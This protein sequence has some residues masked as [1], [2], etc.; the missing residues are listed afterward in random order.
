M[1]ISYSILILLITILFFR[2]FKKYNT[3]LNPATIFILYQIIF[4]TIISSFTAIT[5]FENENS[6]IFYIIKT[7]NLTSLYVFG[8]IITYFLSLS[9]IKK[10]NGYL[11]TNYFLRMEN[12]IIIKRNIIIFILLFIGI[13]AFILLAVIGNGG[14]LWFINSREA[15]INFRNGAGIFYAITQWC[16]IL[17]YLFFIWGEKRLNTK[18]VIIT[19]FTVFIIYFLGS[20]HN[21]LSIIVLAILYYHLK[22]KIISFIKLLFFFILLIIIFLLTFLSQGSILNDLGYY[23]SDYVYTT[24]LFLLRFGEEFQFTYGYGLLSDLWYYV[25]RSIYNL[26]PYEYGTTLIHEI[27]YPGSAEKGHTPGVLPW[28]LW[29]LDFSFIG[30]L[31]FGAITGIFQQV[32]FEN[33][34]KNRNSIIFFLL[35]VQFSFFPVLIHATPLVCI[36]MISTII[37]LSRIRL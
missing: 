20:K 31:F 12:L 4:L 35:A 7:L 25:P 17:A 3:I 30:V 6:S 37:F 23:F 33:Y 21:L 29:Y 2:A 16:M 19:L 11:I 14:F 28:S 27:L 34:L 10:I 32:F 24:S 1:I 9:Y 8:V 26:K 5:R 36:L 18:V 13:L 15:Y 22:I